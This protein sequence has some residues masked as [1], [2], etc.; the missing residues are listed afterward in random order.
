MITLG[1]SIIALMCLVALFYAFKLWRTHTNALTLMILIP[2]LFLWIDNF[3]IAAGRFVGEGALMTGMTYLRFYWHWQTVPLLII[4]AGMLARRAGFGWAQN[5]IVMGVFCLIAVFFMIEDVPYIWQVTF[6][7]ACYGD[8]LRMV[9]NVPA[10]QI[11][12]GTTPFKQASPSPLPVITVNLVLM[13]VGFMMWWKDKFPWLALTCVFMFACAASGPA[14]PGAA[15]TQI[16]G[17]FGEP[18][19]NAGLIAAGFRY[20]GRAKDGTA[21]PSPTPA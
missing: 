13:V 17:N 15:W 18:I 2:L 14:L 7:P 6:Q 8:T 3:A 10:D 1:Y 5:K 19:F 4:V 16:L 21:V 12:E 20:A 11:C 9:I